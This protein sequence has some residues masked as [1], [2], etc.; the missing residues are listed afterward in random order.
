MLLMNVPKR[1]R[2]KSM[3]TQCG[4]LKPLAFLTLAL[5]LVV[6]PPAWAHERTAL[7]RITDLEAGWV[8]E[9]VSVETTAP[10]INPA[11]C[12]VSGQGYV[13]S[14]SDPGRKL[15]HDVLREAFWRGFPVQLLISS[16]D[17]DCPFGKPRI[18]SVLIQKPL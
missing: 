17:G 16:F 3:H 12:P 1:W 15:F 7:G 5:A 11:D 2:H 8:V 9:T 10:V 6:T 18:I 4:A 14:L 13:T